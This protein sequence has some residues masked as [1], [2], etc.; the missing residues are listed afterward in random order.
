MSCLDAG[1][2]ARAATFGTDD[3]HFG[4][5]ISCRR[6]LTAERST[7]DAL[8]AL[9]A[10]ALSGA[11]RKA[12]AAEILAH[13]QVVPTPRRPRVAATLMVGATAL[14]A[15][16]ALVAWWPRAVTG[17]SPEVALA[18]TPEDIAGSTRTVATLEVPPA[19]QAP[20]LEASPGATLHHV[21]GNTRDV[22]TLVDGTL[23]LDSRSARDVD[24]RI[25]DT[26]V[27]VVN[28]AV[29]I[30]AHRR[31]IV[32]VQVRVGAAHIDDT[33]QHVMLQ[34]DS[35]WMPGP[36]AKTRSL[37]AFREA[38]LAL[39]SGHN[40]EA[41]ELF[42]RVSD[43]VALEEATYWAAIAAKRSGNSELAAARLAK[44]RRQFPASKYFSSEESAALLQP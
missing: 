41:M 42:D 16:L 7:R 20:A 15:S 24:V 22:V 29:T 34:R 38:W 9:P 10:P 5:C 11:H 23:T 8:R 30:R 39:R 28:A 18:V 6:Q 17:P 4:E 25:G 37:E 35:L 13:A 19:L 27:R 36:S 1:A 43:P 2:I 44:F 31:E 26:T 3:A 14:A 12:L 32:S 40:R 21:L 33:D